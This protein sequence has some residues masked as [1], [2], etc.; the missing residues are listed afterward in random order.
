VA[1]AEIAAGMEWGEC[2]LEPPP[3]PPQLAA[4]VKKIMGVLPAAIA[5]TA[6]VPWVGRTWARVAH[7]EVAHMPLALWDLISLVV[8]QDNSCR[9]CYGA[10][11]TILRLVGYREEQIDRIERDVAVSDLGRPE[12]VALDFARKVSHANPRPT[13]QDRAALVD[14]GFTPGAVAEIVFAA[15]FV[16]FPNRVATM[17]AMQP[18]DFEKLPD[19]LIGRIFR[20]LIAR[21]MRGKCVAPPRPPE[22]NTGPF[23]EIVSALAGSPKAAVVRDAVDGAFASSI[24][25]T[26]TKLLM[27]A[28]VGRALGCGTSERVARD[29]LAAEGLTGADVDGILANLGSPN[30]DRRDALLV[31]FARETVRY[32]TGSIQRRTREL[33]RELPADEIV[34]AAGVTALANALGRASILVET[35]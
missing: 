5:R 28:V 15:A 12:R 16:G 33:A 21:S 6:S 10:T 19:R 20:P 34:E 31:P 35:C 7:K 1:F 23:R 11:R 30:L 27:T 4:E 13:A 25:P 32:Q 29:G 24:L 3:V 9:Y 8:S 22:P 18:E 17:F 2:W 26:R 14:A